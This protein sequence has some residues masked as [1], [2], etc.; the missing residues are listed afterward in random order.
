MKEVD[1]MK[2]VDNMKEVDPQVQMKVA[3]GPV[4]HEE[5]NENKKCR[6]PKLTHGLRSIEM[7]FQTVGQCMSRMCCHIK[8]K[9]WLRAS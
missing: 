2:E 9:K 5:A 1:V 6:K 8:N 7:G 3:I 4:V